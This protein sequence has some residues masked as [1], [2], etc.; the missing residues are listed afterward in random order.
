MERVAQIPLAEHDDMIKTLAPDR[1]D[2]PLRMPKVVQ[3]VAI[4]AARP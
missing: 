1:A 4:H 3:R 2:Q